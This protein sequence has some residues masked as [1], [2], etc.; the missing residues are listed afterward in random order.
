MNYKAT[1]RRIVSQRLEDLLHFALVLF[2]ERV[3]VDL[4]EGAGDAAVV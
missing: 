1:Y 3:E 2:G 4:G